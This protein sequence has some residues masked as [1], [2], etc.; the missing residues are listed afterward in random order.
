MINPAY[1][2]VIGASDEDRRGLFN[3]AA[4]RIGTTVQNIEK[5]FWVCWTLDAL[6]NR[7]PDGGARL[8]FK[9]GTSLSKSYGLTQRFSEDIDV[10]VFR[11]DIN[12]P[13]TV[14]EM[15]ALPSSTQRNKRLDAIKQACQIDIKDRLRPALIALADETMAAGGQKKG[16]LQIVLDDDDR[17]LQTLLVR[18]PSAVEPSEYVPSSVKIES[19]AKSALDPNEDK[20]VIPYLSP[21]LPDGDTLAVTGVKT[22]MPGR[23][24]LD[25]VLI[26]HGIPISFQADGKLRGNGKVSR[27][28]YDIHRMMA[29]PVGPAS[30]A[31]K[32]LIDD[33]VRHARMFFFK[34]RTGLE[35]VAPG[36]FAL[37]PPNE[38]HDALRRDYV[39][40]AGMI[41]GDVPSFE[42]VLESVRQAEFLLNS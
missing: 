17:Q 37:V 27:H 23:T 24:L 10:T 4:T 8:L 20:T 7:L 30:L 29:D 6:F 42:D 2:K 28:Y 3:A 1:L 5:D 41:F 40:M 18:Y 25:K 34:P 22:I 38:L 11:Q 9:G 13:A 33:C 36:T 14:A 32:D 19:G 31:D 39:A 12:Q 21:D 16:A 15:E 35:D 26:L